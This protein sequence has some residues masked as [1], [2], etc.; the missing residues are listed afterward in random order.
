MNFEWQLAIG[1]DSM[2]AFANGGN[3]IC[4]KRWMKHRPQQDIVRRICCTLCVESVAGRFLSGEN[5]L[6]AEIVAI[7]V[8]DESNLD[9]IVGE[10]FNGVCATC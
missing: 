1:Q 10:P 3:T 6:P 2:V 5:T 8:D 7:A 9:D 4:A